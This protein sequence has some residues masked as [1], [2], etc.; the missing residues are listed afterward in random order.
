VELLSYSTVIYRAQ[1][2][3]QETAA[4]YSVKTEEKKKKRRGGGEE[5]SKL[6]EDKEEEGHVQRLWILSAQTVKQVSQKS[7]SGCTVSR[8]THAYNDVCDDSSLEL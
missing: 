3:L 6:K 5:N 1:D 2:G 4:M 7:K 8:V